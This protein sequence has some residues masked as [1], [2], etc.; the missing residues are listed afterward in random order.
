MD[1]RRAYRKQDFQVNRLIL[2]SVPRGT[3]EDFGSGPICAAAA[4]YG[5]PVG[6]TNVANRM[7]T[8]K[9]AFEYANIGTQTIL[10]PTFSANGYDIAFDNTNAE[11]VELSR[12]ITAQSSSAYTVGADR[13]FVEVTLTPADVSGL[14]ELAVGFR[15]TQAYQVAIDNYTDM[16]VLNVQGGTIN[17]E[18]IL[19]NAATVTTDTGE[20]VGDGETVT[21]RVEV[22][23]D[24]TCKY[25]VDGVEVLSTNTFAFDAT[26]V[27][28]PFVHFVNASDVCDTL[29]VSHWADGLLDKEK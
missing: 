7:N 4:G 16:A 5:N 14:G 3:L 8:G 11:G 29:Y 27:L 1:N 13:F 2:T 24:G 22:Y 15:K 23:S 26:D 20:T 21:L 17:L 12:G 25:Y 19:N 18:T 28:V 10:A 6:T 9:N